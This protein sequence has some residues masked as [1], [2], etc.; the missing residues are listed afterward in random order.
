MNRFNYIVLIAA[1]LFSIDLQAQSLRA[2]ESAAAKAAASKDYSS[3]LSY[4]K[5]ILEDAGDKKIQNY[6]KAAE[7][8]RMAKDYA[9]AESYYGYV[10]ENRVGNE[11]ADADY[12]LAMSQKLQGNYTA[13]QKS[14]ENYANRKSGSNKVLVE[15]ARK[16]AEVAAWAAEVMANKDDSEI[17]HLDDNVNT[18]YAEFS[19]F[20]MDDQ[21]YYSSVR[22]MN[23]ENPDEVPFA[24]IYTSENKTFGVTLKGGI[25][26]DLKHVS[27]PSLS[28]SGQRLY[29][30]I[31]EEKETLV[32]RCDIY[33]R[34]R[35]GDDWGEA[36]KLPETIN[37]KKSNNT[38]PYEGAN[39]QGERFLF[40]ASDR[41]G[42]AG[43]MDIYR[44][45]IDASGT[46]GKPENLR[47]I[48]TA[49]DEVT[50]FFHTRSKTLYYST[51]G[52][53][54]LGGL[55]IYTSKMKD[56]KWIA[57][58]HAGAPL[59]GP[60]DDAY[61]RLNER[62]D[63]GY[64][65]TNRKGSNCIDS[66]LTC[67]CPDI[68]EVKR[69]VIDLI[70]NTYNSI[71]KEKLSGV[72]VELMPDQY[73]PEAQ[74]DLDLNKYFFGLTF[75]ND[76]K[77]KGTKEGYTFDE[78]LTDTQGAR[79]ARTIEKDLFLTPKVDLSTLVFDKR[80]GEPLNGAK[81]VLEAIGADGVIE[82]FDVNKNNYEFDL[83][84][85]KEYRVVASKEGYTTATVDVM[86]KGIPVVPTS[87][88][89]NLFLCRLPFAEYP[90]LAMYFDNDYPKCLGQ[91]PKDPDYIKCVG[92]A[93]LI[94]N[95]DYET[96]YLNYSTEEK[97]KEFTSAF[98]S[99]SPEQQ[100]ITE[101]FDKVDEGYTRLKTFAENL[102][103]LYVDEGFK[104]T[105]TVTIKGYASP[106]AKPGYN[107]DLTQ[108]RV[109]SMVQFLSKYDGGVLAAPLNDGRILIKREWF[110]ENTAKGG[111]EDMND[112]KASVY[113]VDASEE[114][115]VEI[116][117]VTRSE[118]ICP[119]NTPK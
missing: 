64:F 51:D 86:T 91:G 84:W 1:I 14:F 115:R 33:Y 9:Y 70:V 21:L 80:T 37:A 57:P 47:A 74:L 103:L 97:R 10:A 2:Y 101:F 18:C 113:S 104:D 56:G 102:K 114:R 44:S 71:T 38:Q 35:D 4:Y 23:E 8:A 60:Q 72:R 49:S 29:Y 27:N 63:T 48:N 111:S 99:N 46:F 13:A 20:M 32:R 11:F 67:V 68:V 40:Y 112:R 77:I 119:D 106:R 116:I 87:L 28:A 58:Q 42:G 117:R 78:D 118:Y 59:N 82:R 73:D 108:R 107:E 76:Y 96:T 55:D 19:P 98:P 66:T 26:M 89:E 15:S 52:Q 54:S 93:N 17:V 92:Q 75:G 36:V 81:V 50:P 5:I 61:L 45:K 6:Y 7:T 22:I 105:V 65:S 53:K 16:E 12:W 69:P 79:K 95:A 25:N 3:A 41:S 88:S 62:G 110:G 24:R 43:A 83:D 94:A 30:T 90:F 31:C 100:T 39:A 109:N 85:R 34:D